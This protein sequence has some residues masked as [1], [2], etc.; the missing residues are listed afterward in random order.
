MFKHIDIAHPQVVKYAV[1]ILEESGKVTGTI[2]ANL[3]SNVA[4]IAAAVTQAKLFGGSLDDLANASKS[5]LDFESSIQAEMEAEML[6]GK[7]LNLDKAR[8]LALANDLEGVAKEIG[9]NE[10]IMKAFSSGNRIQQEATA[11]AMGMSR[12]EMAKMILEALRN[13]EIQYIQQ[14][15]KKAKKPKDNSKPDW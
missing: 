6:T 1:N 8:Q 12:E 4:T 7:E 2:R 10:G 3:G 11:K 9:K 15:K 13:N 14:N 5:L